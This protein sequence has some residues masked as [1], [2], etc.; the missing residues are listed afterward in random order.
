MAR[1]ITPIT[2]TSGPAA[3]HQAAIWFGWAIGKRPSSELPVENTRAVSVGTV[4][5]TATVGVPVRFIL[6]G[7]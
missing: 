1:R 4:I 5:E 7:G 2:A 6:C 3:D